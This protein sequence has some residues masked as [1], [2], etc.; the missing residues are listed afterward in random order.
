MHVNIHADLLVMD[1]VLDHVLDH[2]SMSAK[3]VALMTALV[4]V[5]HPQ[6]VEIRYNLKGKT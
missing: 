2:V 5:N 3:I 6:K 4:R 1:H